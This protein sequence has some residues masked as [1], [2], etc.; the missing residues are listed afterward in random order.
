MWM[1]RVTSIFL[2]MDVGT[3]LENASIAEISVP[4][5]FIESVAI[6]W[7]FSTGMKA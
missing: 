7:V 6:L 1:R 4:P 3:L 2:K 5:S